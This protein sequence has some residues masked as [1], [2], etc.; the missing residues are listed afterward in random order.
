MRHLLNEIHKAYEECLIEDC[1]FHSHTKTI[2]INLL[3]TTPSPQIQKLQSHIT[4]K[5]GMEVKMVDGHTMTVEKRRKV[6]SFE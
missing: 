2:H 4:N 5:Y 6:T 3:P 1:F